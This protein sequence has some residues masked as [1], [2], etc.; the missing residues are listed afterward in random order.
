MQEPG[1]GDRRGRDAVGRGDVP[2]DAG[3][4]HVVVEVR[5]LEARIVPAE[6]V[7]RVLLGALDAPGQEAAAEG[8][9]GDETDA[10]LAQEREDATFQIALPQRVLA[11]PCRDR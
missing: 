6:V 10:E 2:Y 5:A 7:F 9:E 8:A 3:G 4:A 11:L 1:E